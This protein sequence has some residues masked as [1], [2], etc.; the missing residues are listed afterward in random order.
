MQSTNGLAKYF[1]GGLEGIDVNLAVLVND[2]D[3]DWRIG[4]VREG[5]DLMLGPSGPAHL[6]AF[7]LEFG[8]VNY[9]AVGLHVEGS[10]KCSTTFVVDLNS[11]LRFVINQLLV[12]SH[13]RG[14]G[15]D[16]GLRGADGGTSYL[17]LLLRLL[18]LQVCQGSLCRR[19]SVVGSGNFGAQSANRSLSCVDGGHQIG[20]VEVQVPHFGR[21]VCVFSTQGVD[22][23]LES[24]ELCGKARKLLGNLSLATSFGHGFDSG[25]DEF[26]LINPQMVR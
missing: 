17:R 16:D 8:N 12:A 19:E 14:G 13:R 9:R 21:E 18:L 11:G 22:L 15:K 23:L 26:G 5:G 10:G 6:C 3:V 7:G 2:V 24:G 20:I 25:N 1:T 4:A